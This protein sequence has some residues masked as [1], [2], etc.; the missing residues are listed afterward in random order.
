MIDLLVILTF[1]APDL[2]RVEEAYTTS[3]HY[4]VVERGQV[5]DDL[6]NAWDAPKMSGRDYILMQPESKASYYLRFVQNEA[7]DGYV[8][9]QTFGWNAAELLVKD[10]DALAHKFRTENSIFRI[11][12]E[13]RPLSATSNI[14]A[15]QVVG[16]ANE[17]LYLTRIP[18]PEPSQSSPVRSTATTFVDRPFI[19]ILSGSNIDRLRNFWGATFDAQVSEPSMARMTV[20]NKA[21]ALDIETTHPLAMARLT[22]DFAI[23]LD[24]YPAEA[25]KR[26]QREGELPQA[27][28]IVSVEVDDLNDYADHWLADP[29]VAPDSPYEG[30]RIAF[31]RGLSDELIELIESAD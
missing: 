23:E 6:A 21:M 1:S 9:M 12:G 11:V 18:P 14:R 7:I 19:V 3:L 22:P 13:P 25:K 16:P 5:N 27:M 4:E 10:P 15:M 28:A 24:E 2:A 29:I 20:L 26:P 17:V 8:P 31:I 30:R